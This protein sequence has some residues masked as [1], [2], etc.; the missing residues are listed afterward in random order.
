MIFLFINVEQ[1]WK[2]HHFFFFLA[3][4]IQRILH[5]VKYIAS[6]KE[7][8]DYFCIMLL[9]TKVIV[10]KFSGLLETGLLGRSL[11]ALY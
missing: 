5:T 9:E 10:I 11:L 3:K 1:F 4:Q 7:G 8:F 2:H 6:K